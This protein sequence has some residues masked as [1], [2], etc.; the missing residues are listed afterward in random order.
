MECASDRRLKLSEKK[1]CFNCTGSKQG[2][3]NAVVPK[4]ANFVM[5]KKHISEG[6]NMLVTTHNS[7]VC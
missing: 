1:L 4:L 7:N 5:K 2:P 6:S 3:Q